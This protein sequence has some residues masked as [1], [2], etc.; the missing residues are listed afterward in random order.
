MP[1]RKYCVHSPRKSVLL[2]LV[3]AGCVNTSSAE[4]AGWESAPN[5]ASKV[6]V[7]DQYLKRFPDDGGGGAATD[8]RLT[9]LP[10]SLSKHKFKHI[11]NKLPNDSQAIKAAQRAGE[12]ASR[13]NIQI[14][15]VT[16]NNVIYLQELRYVFVSVF[17]EE[18]LECIHDVGRRRHR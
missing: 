13:L 14:P 2:S 6:L 8:E 4:C 1:S 11:S 5:T 7:S 3:C 17:L 10:V 12:A 16:T 9:T 15:P 18:R